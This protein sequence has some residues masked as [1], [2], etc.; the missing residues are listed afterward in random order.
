MTRAKEKLVMVGNT[1]TLKQYE[2]IKA[3]IDLL[4]QQQQVSFTTNS[5]MFFFQL[6][7]L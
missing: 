5:H 6:F 4:T 1:S 2:P 7:I 3:L